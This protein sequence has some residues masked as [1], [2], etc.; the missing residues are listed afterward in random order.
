MS[1]TSASSS[2]ALASLSA[3]KLTAAQTPLH[4][5]VSVGASNRQETNHPRAHDN[6][7]GSGMRVSVLSGAWLTCTISLSSKKVVIEL[8]LLSR[9]REVV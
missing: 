4:P 7:A 9:G 5:L 8:H 3:T 2:P 1:L 6:K